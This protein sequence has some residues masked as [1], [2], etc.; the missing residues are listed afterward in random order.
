MISDFLSDLTADYL[1]LS[2]FRR[3]PFDEDEEEEEMSNKKAEEDQEE[4]MSDLQVLMKTI[5]EYM[6]KIDSG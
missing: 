4:E 5:K 2:L 1:R 3:D 6:G